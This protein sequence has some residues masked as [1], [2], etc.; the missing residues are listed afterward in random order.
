MLTRGQQSDWRFGFLRHS[1]RL[2]LFCT[3]PDD[4]TPFIILFFDLRLDCQF[5]ASKVKVNPYAK[6]TKIRVQMGQ[7]RKRSLKERRYQ[8]A[9]LSLLSIVMG[10][11]TSSRVCTSTIIYLINL[12][13]PSC[14]AF[15]NST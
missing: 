6:K 9:L 7:V 1:A 12:L 8:N 2:Q 14:A 13:F 11:V 3:K 15:Q 5:L 10:I 4:E